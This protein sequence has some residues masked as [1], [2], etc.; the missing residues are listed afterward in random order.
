MNNM[1]QIALITSLFDYPDHYVPSF[2]RQKAAVGKVYT[3]A[4]KDEALRK[5]NAS[6]YLVPEGNTMRT[7]YKLPYPSEIMTSSVATYEPIRPADLGLPT[8]G[9][10]SIEDIYSYVGKFNQSGRQGKIQVQK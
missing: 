8:Q 10:M 9:A 4:E 5:Y 2:Y 1:K 7:E 6:S 3:Q